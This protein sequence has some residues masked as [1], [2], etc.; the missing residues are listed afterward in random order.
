MALHAL[1]LSYSEPIHTVIE[2]GAGSDVTFLHT[3]MSLVDGFRLPK[4]G[5]DLF[6]VRF[7]PVWGK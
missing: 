3:S 4:V 6:K 7:R 2:P 1:D 5:G